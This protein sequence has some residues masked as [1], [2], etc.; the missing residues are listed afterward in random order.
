[1][2]DSPFSI[3]VPEESKEKVSRMWNNQFIIANLK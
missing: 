3:T 1:M 2:N